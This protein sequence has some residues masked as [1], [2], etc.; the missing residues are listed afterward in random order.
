VQNFFLLISLQA[1]EYGGIVA[2]AV[3]DPYGDIDLF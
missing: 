2:S 1:A 3:E